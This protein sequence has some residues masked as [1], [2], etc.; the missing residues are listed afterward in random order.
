MLT[1]TAGG[2]YE[3]SN[4]ATT[5]SISVTVPGVYGVTVTTGNCQLASALVTVTRDAPPSA[6]FTW[7]PTMPVAPAPA[8]FT[9]SAANESYAW[10][11]SSG[12]PSASA[13]VDPSISWS[14]YGTYNVQLSVTDPL[15][16]CS[17]TTSQNIHVCDLLQPPGLAPLSTPDAD[18]NVHGIV[19]VALATTTV[20]QLSFWN[21]GAGDTLVLT[22]GDDGPQQT[23]TVPPGSANPASIH[24][25]WRIVA[26]VTYALSNSVPNNTDS[27]PFLSYPISSSNIQVTSSFSDGAM[28]SAPVGE[29]AVWEAFTDL[30][31]CPN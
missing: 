27:A 14:S 15:T 1:A 11:F 20:T 12:N 24:V 9:A 26:G 16:G 30:Q 4:G 28:P 7:T 19:F 31:T 3:W 22:G 25:G 6:A 21:Q 5:R 8:S 18:G 2:S 29:T 13:G 17:S 10:L 23:A